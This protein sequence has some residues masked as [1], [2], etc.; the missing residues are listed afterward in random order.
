VIKHF[1]CS[2]ICGHRGQEEQDEA[3]HKVLSKHRFPESK[4]NKETSLAADVV[5]YPIDWDD[6]DRFYMFVGFVRGIAAE[7]NFRSVVVLIGMEIWNKRPEF[8]R[9]ASFRAS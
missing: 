7:M 5:P 6:T 9:P 3:F 8:S 2:V 1:D 4:H